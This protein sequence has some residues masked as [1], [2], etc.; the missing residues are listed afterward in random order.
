MDILGKIRWYTVSLIRNI[1]GIISIILLPFVFLIAFLSRFAKRKYDIG[2]G[3]MPL[4]NN[5][6]FKKALESQGYTVQTYV[7]SVMSG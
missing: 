4:I 1:S 3:P 2:L 7:T 5:I 6:Y